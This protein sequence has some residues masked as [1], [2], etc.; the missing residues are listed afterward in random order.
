MSANHPTNQNRGGVGI[1]YK[2]TL[3]VKIRHDLSFDES[4]VTEIKLHNK[5]IF[6]TVIYRSP[7]NNYNSPEFRNFLNQFKDLHNKIKT[8]LYWRF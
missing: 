2:T 4:L 5:K 8:V 7:A 3:P 6:L 1:Y